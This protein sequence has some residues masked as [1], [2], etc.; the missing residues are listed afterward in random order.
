[1]KA[2]VMVSDTVSAGVSHAPPAGATTS[3]G[4]KP[5]VISALPPVCSL[6]MVSTH[7]LGWSVAREKVVVSTGA[8]A[9]VEKARTGGTAVTTGGITSASSGG[10]GAP[11]WPEGTG[12]AVLLSKVVWVSAMR[13]GRRV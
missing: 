4:G 11:G 2:M 5:F 3:P 9:T 7:R 10:T 12:A 6:S 13:S 1:M 8:G